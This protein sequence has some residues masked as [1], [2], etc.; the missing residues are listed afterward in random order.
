MYSTLES[1][2]NLIFRQTTHEK[3]AAKALERRSEI[4]LDERLLASKVTLKSEI[5]KEA[6]RARR[7]RSSEQVGELRLKFLIR[8][9]N[10]L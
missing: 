9:T 7:R 5:R 4:E 3:S 8:Q 2:F 1:N 10:I 6:R